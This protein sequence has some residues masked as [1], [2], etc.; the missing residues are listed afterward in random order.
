MTD[1]D[2]KLKM[3]N[4]NKSEWNKSE[5]NELSKKIKVNE[6]SKVYQQKD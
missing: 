5:L 4:V 3:L 1:F 2:N 6:I